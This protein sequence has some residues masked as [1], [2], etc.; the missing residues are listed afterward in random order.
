MN[1]KNRYYSFRIV[2]YAKEEEFTE[3]LKYADKWEW[4]Y[5]DKD[6]KED[7]SPKDP[8]YHINLILRQWKTIK[9]VCNL[10]KSD[11]NTFAIPMTDKREAHEYLTHKNDPEKFQYPISN[12]HESSKKLFEDKDTKKEENES[13]IEL[14]TSTK[15]YREK[16]IILGKDYMKNFD[17]YEKF[18]NSML[19][20]EISIQRGYN[21]NYI[22]PIS[23]SDFI[24]DYE[25][26]RQEAWIRNKKGIQKPSDYEEIIKLI[27]RETK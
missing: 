23:M 24:F 3:L 19:E 26:S 12:I 25:T 13:F 16:A 27:K 11:Q 6:V 21:A 17:R 22:T 14:L 15:T 4:I 2:T 8:H 1:E 5:H 18:V 7:G 9:S 10:V 20:Q